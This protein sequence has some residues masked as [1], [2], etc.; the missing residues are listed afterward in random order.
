M[1]GV[2]VNFWASVDK[3]S[4]IPCWVEILQKGFVVV[5]AV[6]AADSKPPPRRDVIVN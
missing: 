4:T 3:M 5:R 6:V 1:L 2:K